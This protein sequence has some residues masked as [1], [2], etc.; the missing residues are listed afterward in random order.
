MGNSILDV[1]EDAERMLSS[2]SDGAGA[3]TAAAATL[4]KQGHHPTLMGTAAAA[5]TSS[6]PAM[7]HQGLVPRTGASTSNGFKMPAFIQQQQQQMKPLAFSPQAQ[8]SQS[9]MLHTQQQ[10]AGPSQYQ[11]APSYPVQTY[12]QQ[13]DQQ[14]WEVTGTDGQVTLCYQTPD[15]YVPAFQGVSRVPPLSF[16]PP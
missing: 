10:Q 2:S 4:R 15:G 14:L 9:Q 8:S 11:T 12:S 1:L 5:A 13:P 16:P 7:V 6:S 3:G